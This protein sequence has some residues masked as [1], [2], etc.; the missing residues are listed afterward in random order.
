MPMNHNND[1]QSKA[2]LK[3]QWWHL[4]FGE[5]QQLWNWTQN[6]LTRREIMPVSVTKAVPGGHGH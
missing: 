3:V 2:F 5:N 4:E 1:Q 6:P